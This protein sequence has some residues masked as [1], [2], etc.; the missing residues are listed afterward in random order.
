MS[1]RECRRL[2][3]EIF[4]G[5]RRASARAV[6]TGVECCLSDDSRPNF[7]SAQHFPIPPHGRMTLGVRQ[8][9]C[10]SIRLD[11]DLRSVAADDGEKRV[12]IRLLESGLKAKLVALK[13]D[14]LIDVA[15]NKER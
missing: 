2:F 9:R 15:D 11:E 4:A 3:A 10:V 5:R 12:S 8:R 6:C 7:F 14:G 13:S 1:A